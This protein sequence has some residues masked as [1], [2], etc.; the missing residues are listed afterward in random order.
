MFHVE[1]SCGTGVPEWH[2]VSL[3]DIRRW[4]LA[5]SSIVSRQTTACE[6]RR[7]LEGTA[8]TI[9]LGEI[10]N[11]LEHNTIRRPRTW[12]EQLVERPQIGHGARRVPSA[13]RN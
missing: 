2:S 13:L 5:Q 3:E 6:S 9:L 12:F 4:S 8:K 11:V 1:H 7:I 10:L